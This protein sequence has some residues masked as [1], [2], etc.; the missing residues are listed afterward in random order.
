MKDLNTITRA[1]IQ[2]VDG[3]YPNI[4]GIEQCRFTLEGDHVDFTYPGEEDNGFILLCARFRSEG[5]VLERV[6]DN[7]RAVFKDNEEMYDGIFQVIQ[8]RC[9]DYRQFTNIENDQVFQEWWSEYDPQN[10]SPTTWEN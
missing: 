6:G 1:D 2:V 5:A 3:K 4:Q 10:I 9:L 7:Y 8:F